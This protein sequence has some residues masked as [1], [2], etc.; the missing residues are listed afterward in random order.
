MKRLT[1]ILALVLMVAM[2]MMAEHVSPETARK[3]ATTFLNNNGAKAT[4]LADLSKAAGF[5][6]LYIFTAEQ[7]FVVMAAD[8]CVQPIL[9][10]SLEGKFV[11]E[12]MPENMIWW[13]QGYNNEI[14]SAIEN[15]T[16]PTVE[17]AK[18]WKDLIEGNSKTAKATV[19]V[20]P[21]IQTK[22][23]QNKYYNSLC[24]EV[25][26]GPDGHAYTGCVA[27]AM[28]Q[29]M[30][31]WSYPAQGIGSH[32]YTWNGQTLSA[33]FGA[34]TYDWAN[35]ANAYECYYVNPTDQYAVA[36]SNTD[37][38]ITAV[39][40]LMYHC[41]VSVDM[42]YG[43]SSTGGSAA[44]NAYV[45]T[46]LKNYFNY[47]S[48]I[49]YKEKSRTN[50]STSTWT[51][52]TYYT[53]ADWI[54]MLK[55]ELDALRP[56]QYG[57]CDP[58]GYSGHAFVCD[59]YNSDN[60]FHFN[61]GWAGHY[62]GYFSINN[63]DTGANS[64]EAGAGNGTY[65]RD[66]DAIFGIRPASMTPAPTNL[67]YTLSGLQ[68]ITLTWDAASGAS[69]YNIY[70]D[71]N[72]IGN[73]TE[74]TYSE[75]A[76]FGTFTYY[77]RSVDANGQLSLGSNTVT[78]TI[79]YQTPIVD[80]LTGTLSGNSVSLSWTA[81]EWCYPETPTATLTYGN[82]TLTGMN[83]TQYWAHRYLAN[84]LVLY[85]GKAVYKVSFCAYETGTYNC[86]IYKGTTNMSNND[87]RPQTLVTSKTIEV[88]NSNSWIDIEMDNRVSIDGENDIWVVINYPNNGNGRYAATNSQ[89]DGQNNHG[90][91][92][93]G[94]TY[95]GSIISYVQNEG[96]AW[97][98]KTYV[99]D[100]TYTYNLYDGTATVAS[101]ISG[102][103][104]TVENPANNTA[105]QYTV[106]TNYYGGETDASN[107]A[108]FTFG[109]ASL[110]ALQM[111]AN[112]KMTVTEG[113][114]LTVSGTLSNENAANLV[115]ENGAQLV[116]SSSNVQAT[117]KKDITAYSQD[118]G[119][120]LIASPVVEDIE[121]TADNGLLTNN[122][123][124]Y[125]FN[126]NEAREWQNYKANAFDAIEN[127]VGYLYANSG[128]T[129]LTFAG[130]L[131]NTATA[132]T[133]V[134]NDDARFK[135]FNLIGN[136]FPCEAYIGRSF[137]V[138][139][140][141]GTNFIESNGAIPPCTAVL[142]QAQS[143]SDN[144]VTFTKTASKNSPSIVAQLKKADIKSDMILDQARVNFN[145]NDN[146]VK[147]SLD[148]NASTLYFPQEGNNFAALSFAGQSEMPLNFKASHN[149]SYT[150]SFAL[151]NA[152]V[153]YLHLIDNMTGADIDLLINNSY[154]FEAKTTDYASRFKLLFNANETDGPSTPST[155]LGTGS[156]TFAFI[157]NGEIII[158]GV[159]MCHGASI[160]IIDMMGH[161][162]V[163][164]DVA[165][166]VSTSGIPAGVY[167]LRLI[168]GDDVKTQKIV[169][170]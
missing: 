86:Y 95:N 102:T 88:T 66:Q 6:N 50:T 34:T 128:G 164:T 146:L 115:L 39:A 27:T 69:K 60:Y 80:D 65:T 58:N 11:A 25:S 40:T 72:L 52:T 156:G 122:Y 142:V 57:G 44:P 158:N 113:S 35:M 98:I 114:K 85:L 135:G 48:E 119:W 103:S 144:S 107:M 36:V 59:G 140:P 154:T 90:N 151:E 73:T 45:A 84:D 120:N 78:V 74:T 92:R 32:S 145:D 162:L 165:R 41:G 130:T 56:M 24:P 55:A 62:N 20:A 94:Y 96:I 166:N 126:Q 53:D 152:D 104:Y 110:T 148:K 1:M 155:D 46:A 127:K 116:N 30:K 37:E 54:S 101:N 23:N 42:E 167:V 29:I 47:N 161:I 108:G 2:P 143:D 31:Y 43:G 12:G 129:D 117:V 19:A 157:S 38:E 21:L 97:L 15:K 111:A 159:E 7:G 150:L 153:D 168:N 49:E 149:G 93:H 163:C 18:M 28:A 75:V 131:A 79:S 141:E 139:N 70:R 109:D 71:G 124:L 14:Q 99:T 33:D 4:Q 77:V 100:G 132:T 9:G 160:Q 68:D 13:L 64:S 5:S 76:P 170:Q 118:G 83:S 136:P 134:Y 82:N 8:D 169:V 63:L 112:D 61:W 22:W 133:L 3:V 17:T 89:Y 16:K 91:Y 51:T 125:T 81:P 147:Y 123:D 87:F 26:D 67:A 121:P 106:K 138:M 137:Y 10:Y 105:H